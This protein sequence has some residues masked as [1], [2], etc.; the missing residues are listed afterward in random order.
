MLPST[1]AYIKRHDKLQQKYG[2][3]IIYDHA[4]IDP[5][6]KKMRKEEQKKIEKIACELDNWCGRN[7]S[8]VVCNPHPVLH[9]HR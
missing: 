7:S 4:K 6:L 5:E 2:H 1:V 3:T 8:C 9:A